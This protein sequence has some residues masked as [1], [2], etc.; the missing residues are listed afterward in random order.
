[1][2]DNVRM[3]AYKK[4]HK[5]ISGEYPAIYTHQGP[6]LFA[7][8]KKLKNVIYNPGRF[9]GWYFREMHWEGATN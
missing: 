1:M 3:G 6:G 5:I 4:A 8:N 9:Q 7:H 2:D